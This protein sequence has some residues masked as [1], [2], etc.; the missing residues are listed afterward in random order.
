MIHKVRVISQHYYSM[1]IFFNMKDILLTI[2]VKLIKIKGQRNGI[3]LL[4]DFFFNRTEHRI[5]KKNSIF[6]D[7]KVH[8]EF[9]LSYTLVV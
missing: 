2:N 4:V 7:S 1:V 3:N 9:V 6:M 5:P 8:N